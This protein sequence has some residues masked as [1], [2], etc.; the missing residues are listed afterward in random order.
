MDWKKQ[1]KIIKETV[2]KSINDFAKVWNDVFKRD[3]RINK[4]K[5]IFNVDREEK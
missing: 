3:Y 2:E 5:K 1:P 4:I